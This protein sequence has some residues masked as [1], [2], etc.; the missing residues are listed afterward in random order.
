MGR[1]VGVL[2]ALGAA[3]LFGSVNVAA[4][5]ALADGLQ[6]LWVSA[7]SYVMGGVALSPVLLR[8]R[9]PRADLPRL[10]VVVLAGAIAAPLLLFYGLS[11][12]SA[13]DGSLLLN[14]EMLFTAVLAFVVLRERM[15]PREALGLAAI[16][17]GAVLVSLAARAE[18]ATSLLG[19]ALVAAAALGWG[20]D[21]TAS[22][23]LA[24]RLD[25]RALIAW[26]TLVGGAVVLLAAL[27]LSGAPGGSPRD[28]ALAAGAGLVGVAVSSVLFY[29]AL[30]HIGATRTTVLFSTSGLVGA[31]LGHF[32]LGEAW[33][34]LHLA[35]AAA[36]LAGIV[37][38]ATHT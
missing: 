34:W 32:V 5:V 25:P 24:K 21:N 9:V 4:R 11:R 33:T 8:S 28:W 16:A 14:L 22:T 26:K 3:L 23:P 35:G 2:S 6:P 12:T 38:V 27:A 31:A 13:V 18:G 15:R 1:V 20:I 30:R 7:L 10:G 29:R 19:A 36:G 37:V 17:L